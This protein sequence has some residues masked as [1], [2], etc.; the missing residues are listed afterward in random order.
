MVV[1]VCN[2]RTWELEAGGSGLQ[3]DPQIHSEHEVILGYTTVDTTET[4]KIEKKSEVRKVC[5]CPSTSWQHGWHNGV[6][7][8]VGYYKEK[9]SL[10][11]HRRPTFPLRPLVLLSSLATLKPLSRLCFSPST[12]ETLCF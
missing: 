9:Q 4:K 1:Y 10:G 3:G 11:N 2:H 6:P 7:W 12:T 5:E 8:A